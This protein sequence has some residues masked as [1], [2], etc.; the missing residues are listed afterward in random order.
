MTATA[1]ITAQ[2]KNDVVM[3]PASY[4]HTDASGS[5]VYVIITD[6]KTEKRAIVSG[7]RGSD[8]MV[9]VVKGLSEGDR[10]NPEAL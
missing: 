7:L 2:Q 3:I 8:S 1:T 4:I 6:D 9:E 10:V 5:Y